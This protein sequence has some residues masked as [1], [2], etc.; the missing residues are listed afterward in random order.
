MK[1]SES[2][3][4][5][6]WCEHGCCAKRATWRIET[7]SGSQAIPSRCYKTVCDKHAPPPEKRTRWNSHIVVTA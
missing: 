7:P 6:K 4:K 1:V 5:D 3:E 2:G